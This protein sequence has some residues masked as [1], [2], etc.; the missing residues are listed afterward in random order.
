[1]SSGNVDVNQRVF[2][3][4]I[5]LYEK[6]SNLNNGIELFQEKHLIMAKKIHNLL[7]NSQYLTLKQKSIHCKSQRAL[8]KLYLK[9]ICSRILFNKEF[10]EENKWDY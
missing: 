5:T 3:S 6:N 8:M 2:F 10:S 7:Q 9:K 4:E 1:M